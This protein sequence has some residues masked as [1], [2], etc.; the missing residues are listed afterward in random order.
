M[1]DR[2]L[3]ITLGGWI[4]LLWAATAPAQSNWNVE[5]GGGVTAPTGD[6]SSHLTKG[7]NID[8]GG[9]YEFNKTLELD[10]NFVFNGLGVSKAAL[11]ALQM[12]DGN[13]RVMSLTVGPKVH[14]PI[15]SSLSGY[16]AGGAGWYRRTVEFTQP[17]VAVV[18]IIDPWWGYLG[19]EIVPANQVLGSVSRN[20]WGVNGGGGVSVALG[21]SG[22]ELFAE[23]RYHYAHINP[24]RT[25]IVPVT[26]G[27]RFTGQ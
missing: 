9:G 15:A 7:W 14:F 11:Q 24:T 17:T 25:S 8:L 12:P 2:W 22:A 10:A 13:A 16:V 19:S 3:R 26:F 4:V 1:K 20:A 21:H 6:I 18:D 27:V 5:V 23:V